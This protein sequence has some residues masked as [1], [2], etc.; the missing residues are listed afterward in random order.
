[1]STGSND[2]LRRLYRA[3]AE[4]PP[5]PGPH[6]VEND[7]LLTCWSLGHLS[8]DELA[9][10]T[11]HLADCPDCR[12]AL[13]GLLRAGAL[14]PPPARRP[15]FSRRRVL[16]FALAL[17]GAAAAVAIAVSLWPRRARG[18]EGPA[19]ELDRAKEELRRGDADG[20]LA[21]VEGLLDGGLEEGP[22]Q[23]ALA[24]LEEAG[25][26]KGRKALAESHFEEVQRL[27]QRLA[28]RGAGSARL[29]NLALQA[30]RAMPGERALVFAGSLLDYGYEMDGL[31]PRKGLPVLDE[32]TERRQK[33]W[34]R[35]VAEHPKDAALRINF[36]QFLVSL[37]DADEAE[38]QFEAARALG[39][40]EAQAR[41]GLGLA[42]YERERYDAALAHFRAAARASPQEVA[43][44]VNLAICLERL[45]RRGEARPHW[46]RARALAGGALRAAIDR[47]LQGP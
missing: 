1:M 26:E 35:A 33:A 32:Q 24:L 31:A 16:R 30:E 9:A 4:A 43:A 25:Y 17:S 23:R 11:A 45:E 27:T 21:R 14:T 2:R 38:K 15:V 44:H 37:G 41:L 8:D 34:E 13:T 20:A 40:A 18:P 10:F 22:R 19:A 36:G 3:A 29:S 47:H 6:P 42:A 12:R 5:V 46:L 28:G 39:G 7:E